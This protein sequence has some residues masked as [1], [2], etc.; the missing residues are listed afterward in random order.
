MAALEQA[1]FALDERT[2]R[3]LALNTQEDLCDLLTLVK[4]VLGK[5]LESPDEPK[6]RSLRASSK[7]VAACV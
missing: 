1:P 3:A 6:F 4:K 5:I 7:A 2:E